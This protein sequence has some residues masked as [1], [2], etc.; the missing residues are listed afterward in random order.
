VASSAMLPCDRCRQGANA[1]R[2]YEALHSLAP[3]SQ[4]KGKPAS[5]ASNPAVCVHVLLVR[6]AAPGCRPAARP[7]LHKSRACN[8]HDGDTTR[9]QR[10]AGSHTTAD[11]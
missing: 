9:L 5:W 3:A 4:G 10:G 2:V 6:T 11:S 7:F 1:R 8:I